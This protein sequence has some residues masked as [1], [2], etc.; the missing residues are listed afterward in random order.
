M[1][2]AGC[3]FVACIQL[4]RT[5]ISGSLEC[6]Q[7]NASVHKLDL[8]LYS[9]PKECW[10]N[11]VRTHINSNGTNPLYHENS[12][13]RRIEPTTLHPA[14]QWAQHT[15]NELFLPQHQ[16]TR[17]ED[18]QHHLPSV[19]W[20]RSAETSSQRLD[21][22]DTVQCEWALKN[23]LLSRFYRPACICRHLLVVS[24]SFS[25]FPAISLGFTIFGEIFWECD[26]FLIQP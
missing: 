17:L 21:L 11:G 13:Q 24:S 2:H 10:G 9:H 26:C 16:P 19:Y 25:A 4:S 8:G 3:V 22:T 1:I 5:W 23:K 20:S 18:L 15:I 12:T 6:V 14:G 7:W